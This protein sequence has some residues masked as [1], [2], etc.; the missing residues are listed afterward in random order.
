MLL[1]TWSGFSRLP[2]MLTHEVNSWPRSGEERVA[3]NH[4][5]AA[6]H[7]VDGIEFSAATIV[8]LR[9]SFAEIMCPD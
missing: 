3:G 9:N 5:I 2:E 1:L 7:N 4:V 6:I 8:P